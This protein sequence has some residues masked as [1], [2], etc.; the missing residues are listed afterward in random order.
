MPTAP[1]Q[2]LSSSSSCEACRRLSATIWLSHRTPEK[3]DRVKSGSKETA[4]DESTRHLNASMLGL[5]AST[6]SA[7]RYN[8]CLLGPIRLASVRHVRRFVVVRA[9]SLGVL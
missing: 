2:A 8:V 5:P 1:M 9:D 6:R 3:P 4:L 7:C